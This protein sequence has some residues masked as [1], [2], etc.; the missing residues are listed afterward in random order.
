MDDVAA[1]AG[2]S[3]QTVYSHFGSKEELYRAVIVSKCRQHRLDQDDLPDI[4]DPGEALQQIGEHY[5]ALIC[6]PA[7]MLRLREEPDEEERARHVED[8]VELFM[9]LYGG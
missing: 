6:D 3:K 5:L 1:D 7:V 4:A 2:V 8:V 9:R